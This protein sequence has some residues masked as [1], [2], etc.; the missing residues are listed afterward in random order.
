MKKKRKKIHRQLTC[1]Q[2]NNS[3]GHDI[4][5]QNQKEIKFHSSV[6]YNFSFPIEGFYNTNYHPEFLI[7]S[8]DTSFPFN[9]LRKNHGINPC[10]KPLLD[11]GEKEYEVAVR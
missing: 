4:H 8:N 9:C 1:V 2:D 10:P 11:S 7:G 5:F 3:N 6:S